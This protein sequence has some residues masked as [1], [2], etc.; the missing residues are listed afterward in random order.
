MKSKKCLECGNQTYQV[1]K[2][3]VACKIGVSR[4]YREL[5]DLLKKDK[6]WNLRELHL[7]DID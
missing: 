2:I 5:I 4:I 7:T 1:D 6:R 3:C